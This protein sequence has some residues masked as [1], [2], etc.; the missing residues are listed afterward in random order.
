MSASDLGIIRPPPAISDIARTANLRWLAGYFVLA[1]LAVPLAALAMRSAPQPTAVAYAVLLLGAVCIIARPVIGIYLI[2]FLTLLGDAQLAWWYPFNK[3]LSSRESVLYVHDSLIFSPLELYL[4]LTTIVWLLGRLDPRRAPFERGTLLWPVLAFT[5]FVVLGFLHGISTN[6]DLNIA[7]WEVRPIV[8][9]PLL[10]VLATNLCTSRRHYAWLLATVVAAISLE[11]VHALY[12]IFTANGPGADRLAHLGY[13]EHSASLHVNLI[14]VLLV[15]MVVVRARAFGTKLVLSLLIIPVGTMYL[16]AERRSAV[17]A[18]IV[19]LLLA[20]IV[21]YRRNR[22]AFWIV[23]PFTLVVLTL[24]VVAFWNI[25]GPAGLPAQAIKSAIAPNHLDGADMRSNLYRQIETYNLVQTVRTNPL[26]GLGFGQ[27][28]LRFLPL[29]Y[30]P[31]VWQE[32][33]PHN[34]VLWIW[35]KTGL[36]GFVAMLYLFSM[37]IAT[38]ARA[39]AQMRSR[40]AAALALTATLF[41]IMYMIYTYVDISWDTGSMVLLGTMLALVGNIARFDDPRTESPDSDDRVPLSSTESDEDDV[42]FS[43]VSVVFLGEDRE[44]WAS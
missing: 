38:G 29:P 14:V 28:F 24:Y 4:T 27:K 42:P 31:F 33:V 11:A 5:A 3:N 16:N 19:A 20:A 10:Y 35:I 8:Y 39:T 34:A 41:M 2:V 43:R 17:V 37:T 23:V 40:Q 25:G 9:V 21:L 26:M 15:A 30:I 22:A 36:G 44:R 6:G 18:L 7:L 13:L 32:Y 12:V 1:M